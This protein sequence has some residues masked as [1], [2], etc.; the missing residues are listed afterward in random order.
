MRCMHNEWWP[1]SVVFV[2]QGAWRSREE[3]STMPGRRGKE[4]SVGTFCLPWGGVVQAEE[5]GR[6]LQA[7]G[8][9]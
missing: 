5:E 8:T 2:G 7:E 4:G 1:N 6:A 9:A 3:D